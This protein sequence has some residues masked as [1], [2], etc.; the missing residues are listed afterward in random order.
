MFNVYGG[1]QPAYTMT[2]SSDNKVSAYNNDEITTV[3]P[4]YGLGYFETDHVRDQVTVSEESSV[5]GDDDNEGSAN[6]FIARTNNGLL[7]EIEYKRSGAQQDLTASFSI[8]TVIQITATGF[9]ADGLRPSG[10]GIY[11]VVDTNGSNLVF[12]KPIGVSVETPPQAI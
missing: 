1:M 4:G 2:D 9:S 7:T 10:Q 3:Q 11:R 8:G 12:D 6:G 5:S